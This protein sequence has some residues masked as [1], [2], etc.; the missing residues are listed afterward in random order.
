MDRAGNSRRSV[1]AHTARTG[2]SGPPALGVWPSRKRRITGCQARS[3]SDCAASANEWSASAGARPRPRAPRRACPLRQTAIEQ[4]FFQS[5]VVA[6]KAVRHDGAERNACDL[7]L[8]NERQHNLRLGMKRHIVLASG[9][10]H[11]RR[12][13]RYMQR[14]VMRF[15]SSQRG[16]R[17][18]GVIDS[19]PPNPGIGALHDRWRCRPCGPP[20]HR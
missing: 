11:G 19:G 8:L 3:R 9:Q 5:P 1:V 16:H 6:I 17:H 7:R 4:C 10:S 2:L 12:V 15:V 14:I 18:N 13:R 20:C